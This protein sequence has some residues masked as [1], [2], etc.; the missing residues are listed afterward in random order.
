[1]FEVHGYLP[2]NDNFQKE[3]KVMIFEQIGAKER[4]QT[5]EKWKKMQI[6]RVKKKIDKKDNIFMTGPVS[7]IKKI[8]F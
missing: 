5:E 3:L 8:N 1:M 4:I 7:E 6:R 2:G